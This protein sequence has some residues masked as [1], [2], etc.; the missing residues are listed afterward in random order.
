[1]HNPKLTADTVLPYVKSL[2]KAEAKAQNEALSRIL[3]LTQK[4]KAAKEAS[5]AAKP[6]NPYNRLALF[7]NDAPTEVPEVA[8]KMVNAFGFEKA[9]DYAYNMAETAHSSQDQHAWETLT[10]FLEDMWAIQQEKDKKIILRTAEDEDD[11]APE[12][13]LEPAVEK[14]EAKGTQESFSLSII[15][16]EKQQAAADMAFNGKSFVLIGPAGSGKTTAQ[17]AVASSLLKQGKLLSCSY[18]ILGGG[19]R[20][21]GPSFVA[22]AYT[23]RA[24]SNLRKAMHKDPELAKEFAHNIMSIH[25]LLEYAPETYWDSVEM[26]EKFRFAPMRTAKNPLTITHLVIEESSMVG[27]DLWEKLYDAL[28]EGVQIIFIGDINQLPPVFG[29]SILNYA[30]LQLP[31]VELTEVYRNQGIVLENAHNILKGQ[32]L[33]QNEH[34][35]IV[36]G[37]AKVQ[38]G[39]GRMAT[40]IV[41]MLKTLFNARDENG[42]RMY[43]P[44]YDM[45]LTPFN[46]QDMGTIN[47]NKWL[48]QFIGE[49]RGAIVHEVIAGFN[50]LY[51]AEG[52][53]VMV[54][55]M[56]G[57]IKSIKRN[58]AYHGKEPQLPGAD[59]TRFGIRQ[60]GKD[61]NIDLDDFDTGMD[62]STFSLE[63]LAEEKADRVQQ[64]SHIITVDLGDDRII[65]MATAGEFA[66]QVF[67]L[68]YC[69]TTHKAQGSE[70][71]K[72]FIA[73]HKDHSTLLFREWFY[74]AVTRARTDVIIMAKEFIV[75]KAIGTQRIKGNTLKDKLA[76]FNSGIND[77]LTVYCTK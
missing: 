74:T 30:M 32:P 62:Y 38:L 61:A 7:D 67:S 35:K 73:M 17:R 15:L 25:Q 65:E 12:P 70:W 1:M 19:G 77:T 23:R 36:S 27:L 6:K 5:Q 68:G 76:F 16:N 46:K 34:F 57:F 24:A 31:I 26:K 45:L 29:P 14:N 13:S 49:E 10:D 2:V 69:L 59:L 55:K 43:D 42:M 11:L 20:V 18:K 3:A 52:D 51:L 50:K 75:E 48:A 4:A 21:T 9:I 63:S 64:A 71:R 28:P 39:Q 44:D 8:A 56:D 58:P 37:T 72:V 60:L 53:K 33:V 54:D 47:M 41:N 22:C 66:E 40:G